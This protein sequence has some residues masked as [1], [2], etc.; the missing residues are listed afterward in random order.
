M[1]PLPRPAPTVGKGE[2]Q[3]IS[4]GHSPDPDDAFMFFAIAKNKIPREGLRFDH[5]LADIETLNQLA[6]KGKLDVTAISLHAYAYVANK[7]AL[8]PCGI[9]M[10][11]G[12][13]PIVVAKNPYTLEDLKKVEIAVPGEK[14]SAFLA[15]RLCLGEFSHRVVP[16]DRIMREVTSGKAAAGLII[17]EGQLTYRREG[18]HGVV[19][20]GKWWLDQ[21]GLPLPLGVNVVKRSLGQDVMRRVSRVVKASIAFAMIHR[22]DAL[23][24]AINFGRGLDYDLND[25]FVG[26]YVNKFTQ[27]LGDRGRKAMKVFLQEGAL[28][29]LVPPVDD[30]TF[31]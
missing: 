27:D 16:F 15:L 11:E 12:Y 29:G 9:S 10:G 5:F 23:D 3:D 24:Y 21:T 1:T 8:L 7:Y 14:T 26:M 2:K 18:L 25:A 28:K 30:W 4:L 19:D 17:H 6:Q 22:R 13:G 20:L 31:V